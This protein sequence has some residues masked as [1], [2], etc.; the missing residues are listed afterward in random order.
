MSRY[1]IHFEH[2]T[3]LER[4]AA[5]ISYL[6]HNPNQQENLK[7][8]VAYQFDIK[9]STLNRT[10]IFLKNIGIIEEHK[11]YYVLKTSGQTAAAIQQKNETFLG[12]F[13][14]SVIYQQFHVDHKH[15]MSWVYQAVI[16][17]LWIRQTVNISA[18]KKDIINQ[19]AS[20]ASSIFQIPEQDVAFSGSSLSGLLKWIQSLDP[21]V[22]NIKNGKD[23][24]QCRYF[25]KAPVFIK[26]VDWLYNIEQRNYGVKLFLRDDTKEK[27]CQILVL[28]PDGLENTLDNAKNTYNYDM[29]GIFDWGYEGGYGQWVMLSNSPNWEDLL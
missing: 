7:E 20:Q 26:A 6:Y 24:F 16:N 9:A 21:P 22:I 3:N 18:N 27:L 2:S 1:K 10:L 4:V 5:V 12:E 29:G 23:Y 8:D 14:H 25:C 19:I 11:K 17:Q 28:H 13:L 15:T